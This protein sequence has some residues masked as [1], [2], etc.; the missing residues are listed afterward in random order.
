MAARQPPEFGISSRGATP[1]DIETRILNGATF[2]EEPDVPASVVAGRSF[3]IIGVLGF[4]C[5][6]CLRKVPVRAVVEVDNQER[7]SDEFELNGRGETA[8]FDVEI[9]AP[10]TSG[11]SLT[12]RVRAE[13]LNQG[14]AISNDWKVDNTV[15]PFEVNAVTE[16][17][18][19]RETATNFAPWAIG[20]AAL[21]AGVASYTE[22]DPLI[23]GVVGGGVGIGARTLSEQGG[24]GGIV[25]IPEV[26]PIQAVT[27]AA[28]LGGGALFI[29]EV[30][31]VGLPG[32][33]D[34]RERIPSRNGG[35]SRQRPAPRR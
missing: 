30:T 29:G 7:I 31:D 14:S 27:L 20:G 28:L 3:N 21:G 23:G 5:P 34:V 9:A 12:I 4:D 1:R 13:H 17:E 6:T 16:G 22:R 2:A 32:V 8:N 25:G 19:A 24:I 26:N 15:G 33:G 10:P 35:Q 18:K 11:Q